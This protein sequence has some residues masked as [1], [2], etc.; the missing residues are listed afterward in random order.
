MTVEK[1]LM[2]CLFTK[3][4]PRAKKY[5][6]TAADAIKMAATADHIFQQRLAR[7][8][9]ITCSSGECL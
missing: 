3:A 6:F 8:Y 9:P 2:K 1:L 7:L 4:V 5:K